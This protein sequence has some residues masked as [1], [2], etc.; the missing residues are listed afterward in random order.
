LAQLL[1]VQQESE[2]PLHDARSLRGA[3]FS[4]QAVGARIDDSAAAA[5][6]GAAVVVESVVT[7]NPNDHRVARDVAQEFTGEGNAIILSR[8]NIRSQCQH[9]QLETYCYKASFPRN[10]IVWRGNYTMAKEL[11]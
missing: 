2:V 5:T 3:K 11:E 1:G 4:P 6:G 10:T 9:V 7:E 8:T